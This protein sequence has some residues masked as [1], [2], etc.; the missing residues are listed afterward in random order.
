MIRAYQQ[1]AEQKLS[2]FQSPAD[3]YLEG[4]LNI[5][6]IIVIDPHC[7]FYFQMDSK[8]MLGK[9]L[10]PGDIL[11]IDKSLKPVH[12]AVV[13]AYVQGSFYCRT[14]ED[15]GERPVLVGDNDVLNSTDGEVL[16]VWGVVTSFCRGMLPKQLKKGKY[17]RV[18]AL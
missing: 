12:G 18:C 1:R 13:V 17:K 4:R 16:Q 8:C 14:Y 2:G 5:A 11:V 3:D 6:D 15:T 9:G 10:N 7:T